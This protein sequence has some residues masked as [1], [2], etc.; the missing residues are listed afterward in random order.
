[1]EEKNYTAEEVAEICRVSPWT[2]REWLKDDKHPLVGFKPHVR[3]RWLIPESN[4]KKY[5]ETT[6]G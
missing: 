4:L 2:V 1:M 6:N 3:S 5:L